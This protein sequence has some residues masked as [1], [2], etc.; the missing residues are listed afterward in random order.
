MASRRPA[1][2]ARDT[3]SKATRAER[4]AA[5]RH[6]SRSRPA[7]RAAWESAAVRLGRR[8]FVPGV[9]VVAVIAAAGIVVAG[10]MAPPAPVANV[11]RPVEGAAAAPVT[12]AEYSDYQC[13]YC[14]RWARGVEAT[15]RSTFITT[16]QVRFEWHDDAWEGQ[17]S[18]DAANAARC[19]GDQ[20]QFW[21]MHDLL[22]N[23]QGTTPNTGAFTKDKLKGLG[24]TLGL[25]TSSFNACVDA[26]TYNRAVQTD[27]TAATTAGFTGT[28]AFS[29]NGQALM[30]YQTMDQLSAAITAAASAAP[31][32]SAAP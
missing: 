18:I 4:R 22:Y 12:V 13:D 15:F 5:A 28:P 29:V 24:A 31:S 19:A 1:D 3:G 27:T 8:W 32:G 26:G 21:P 30:G 17:E 16:G 6:D 23:S 9:V 20:G 2:T 14:G 10:L 11:V 25:D 7:P